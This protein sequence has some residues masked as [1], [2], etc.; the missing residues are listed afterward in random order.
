MVLNL[1][2]VAD[3]SKNKNTILKGQTIRIGIQKSLQSIIPNNQIKTLVPYGQGQ[4]TTLGYRLSQNHLKNLFLTQTQMDILVGI[5]LGD[6]H[7]K[8]NEQKR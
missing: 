5:M 3:T 6:C 4:G 1:I 2:V 7:I 8:K